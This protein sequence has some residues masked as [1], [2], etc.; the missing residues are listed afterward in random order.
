MHKLRL[1]V[2]V[3]TTSR[4]R[5]RFRVRA[6]GRIRVTRSTCRCNWNDTV[7][8]QPWQRKH[9]LRSTRT[10]RFMCR[11]PRIILV[12]SALICFGCI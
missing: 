8:L 12:L 9:H 1:R 4:A 11:E 3:T 7:S 2:R 6:M 10:T 5:L